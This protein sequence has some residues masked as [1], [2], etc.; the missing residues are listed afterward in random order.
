MNFNI[1][2]YQQFRIEEKQNITSS[3][4]CLSDDELT[5]MDYELTDMC[6]PG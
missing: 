2:K 3:C 1:I 5:D 6:K 4:E